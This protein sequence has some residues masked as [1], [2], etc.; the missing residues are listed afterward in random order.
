MKDYL[1]IVFQLELRS[2]ALLRVLLA[3]LI[4]INLTQLFPDAGVFLS[5]DGFL[6]RAQLN[7]TFDRPWALSLYSMH[8]STKRG[9]ALRLYPPLHAP[10]T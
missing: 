9:R 3:T 1:R 7:E 4:L 8:H 6:S 5:D 2:L 10:L